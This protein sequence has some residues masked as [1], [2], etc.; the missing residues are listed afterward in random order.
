M[1][2]ASGFGAL[3]V[4]CGAIAGRYD[5]PPALHTHSGGIRAVS[6]LDL[7]G[8]V[9]VDPIAA[10]DLAHRFDTVPY[11]SIPNAIEES[12]PDVAVVASS[13]ISH[14]TVVEEILRCPKVPRVIILEKPAASNSKDYKKLLEAVSK[15]DA[16]CLVNMTRRY[17]RSSLEIRKIIKSE[18]LGNPTRV[19]C[20]YYGGLWNN[21]VHLVDYLDM[22]FSSSLENIEIKGLVPSR[23]VE[24]PCVEFSANL[25]LNRAE[26]HVTAID[27]RHF[28]A[29]EVD[30]WFSDG[31]IEIFDFGGRARISVVE[32]NNIG[33]RVLSSTLNTHEASS[34]GQTVPMY[35]AIENLLRRGGP[36]KFPSMEINYQDRIMRQIAKIY[37]MSQTWRN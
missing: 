17:C 12:Q 22:L 7:V 8:C 9:D 10:H 28:Q 31:R 26:L 5:T 6:G 14:R 29:F 15:S 11:L 4:G 23:F 16:L 27:E 13:T 30:I 24:D 1:T 20:K 3:I 18:E 32:T 36:F 37:D 33:E 19:F 35:E 25:G 21:G 2:E 34:F